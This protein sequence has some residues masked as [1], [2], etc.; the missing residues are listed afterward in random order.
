MPTT[1]INMVNNKH[2]LNKDVWKACD[3]WD[4]TN[5]LNEIVCGWPQNSQTSKNKLHATPSVSLCSWA[6]PRCELSGC[7]LPHSNA[8]VG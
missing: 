6:A 3:Y 5:N 7:L 8:V 4:Y 1:S 2:T